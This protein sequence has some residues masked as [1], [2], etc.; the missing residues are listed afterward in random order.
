M[1]PL[2]SVSLSVSYKP[3]WMSS[4]GFL[5]KSYYTLFHTSGV[6]GKCK[7]LYTLGWEA[8]ISKQICLK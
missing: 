3:Q 8:Y 4:I 6:Q 7:E 5:V 2:N 1:Y